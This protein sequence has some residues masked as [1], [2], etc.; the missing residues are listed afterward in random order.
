MPGQAKRKLELLRYTKFKFCPRCGKPGV[1][2]LRKNAMRCESCRFVYFQNCA[3]A[4]A[5]II[6]TGKGIILTKRADEPKKGAYDLP[7]G[8]VDYLESLEGALSREVKEELNLQI[9][10]FQYLGSFPNVYS[11]QDV[12]YFTTDAIFVVKTPNLDSLKISKEIEEIVISDP[13]KID[14]GKIAFESIKEGI[15]RYV[16]R[17][18]SAKVPSMP[19]LNST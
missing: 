6:E 1:V 2:E 12:T 3:A 9:R 15:R 5:G 7:G 16:K 17:P 4:V 13:G 8:F 11:Y 18:K 19:K 14:L 10:D